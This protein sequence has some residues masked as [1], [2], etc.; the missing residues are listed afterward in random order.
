MKTRIFL[1]L[2]VVAGVYFYFG[3]PLPSSHSDDQRVAYVFAREGLGSADCINIGK[4]SRDELAIPLEAAKDG[5]P[6]Q[7]TQARFKSEEASEL[8]EKLASGDFA[9]VHPKIT[10]IRFGNYENGDWC[11][12][13]ISPFI[14]A[15][16]IAI[17][18]FSSPGGAIGAHV[19]KR[20]FFG[21]RS[22]ERVHL[23]WW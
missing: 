17:V 2:A 15:E 5:P 1:F 4:E 10:G 11:G 3:L 21:W 14:V 16:D 22:I 13:W 6:G 19:F 12:A 9:V 7:L 23:A 20:E 18:R 8:S